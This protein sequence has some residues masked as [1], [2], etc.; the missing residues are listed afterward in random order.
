MGEFF[1]AREYPVN[2]IN[3]ANDR[4]ETV[5]RSTALLQSKQR[6]SNDRIPLVLPYHP[7]IHVIRRIILRNY[8]MHTHV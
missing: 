4:M 7:S 3:A 8:T 1:T 2:I 5:N 6:Q